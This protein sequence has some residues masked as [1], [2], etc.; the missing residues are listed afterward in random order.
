MRFI[1]RTRTSIQGW[2]RGA[3]GPP[4]PAAPSQANGRESLRRSG[5]PLPPDKS[6]ALEEP[7]AMN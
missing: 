4:Q 3:A 1:L 2:L 6:G 7:G 5:T